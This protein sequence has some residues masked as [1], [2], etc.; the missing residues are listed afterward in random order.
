MENFVLRTRRVDGQ[1]RP[2]ML[3][4][5]TYSLLQETKSKTGIP[6]SQIAEQAVLFALNRLEIIEED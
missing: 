6:M 2:I 4:E 1:F 5:S 3:T